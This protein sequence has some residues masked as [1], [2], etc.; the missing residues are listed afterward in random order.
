MVPPDGRM[1]HDVGR[2]A[3]EASGRFVGPVS[4]THE[5]RL[6]VLI[7]C[8]GMGNSVLS[9][10]NGDDGGNDNGGGGDGGDNCAPVAFVTLATA[11]WPGGHGEFGVGGIPFIFACARYEM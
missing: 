5:L 7:P 9:W 10:R 6:I 8:D 3:G 1:Q 2:S 4:A 11:V